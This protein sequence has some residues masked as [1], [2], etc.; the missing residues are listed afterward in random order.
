MEHGHTDA[1]KI[2]H[3]F[4]AM[5]GAEVLSEAKTAVGSYDSYKKVVD[6]L[7]QKYDQ[8]MVV[9]HHHVHKLCK[10]KTMSYTC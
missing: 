2:S 1:E 4:S 6:H 5:Q 9:Y 10:Q 7:R 8:P 3:L